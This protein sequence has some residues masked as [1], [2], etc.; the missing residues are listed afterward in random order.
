MPTDIRPLVPVGPDGSAGGC[1]GL[2]RLK[3]DRHS[4]FNFQLFAEILNGLVGV[5]FL[6]DGNIDAVAQPAI[7]GR[8]Y[9]HTFHFMGQ[10]VSV[11]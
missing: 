7:V 8:C 6:R 11:G 10:G 9:S 2:Q 5:G 3:N 1:I 4:E